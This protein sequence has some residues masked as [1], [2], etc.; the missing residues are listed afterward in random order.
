MQ[1][2]HGSIEYLFDFWAYP[3]VHLLLLRSSM[4]KL[5]VGPLLTELQ[6][7]SISVRIDRR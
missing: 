7:E 1:H 2:M 4:G 3:F 5:F 6:I